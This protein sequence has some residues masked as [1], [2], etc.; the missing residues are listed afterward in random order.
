MTHKAINFMLNLLALLIYKAHHSLPKTLVFNPVGAVDS[1]R[2]IPALN[3]VGTLCPGLDSFEFV[4]DGEI[5]CLVIAC[6]EMQKFKIPYAPP[7]T[8][9]QGV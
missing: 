9:E 5:D 4:S 7:A 6:L 8:P 2:Q 3:F 1:L